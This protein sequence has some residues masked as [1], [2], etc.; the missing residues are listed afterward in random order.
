MDRPTI[1]E[2]GSHKT[3]GAPLT[4]HRST[5]PNSLYVFSFAPPIPPISQPKEFFDHPI[6]L[7]VIGTIAA[8]IAG[9]A[10]PAFDIITGVWTN[11]ITAAGAT[12]SQIIAGG[13]KAGWI[14]AVVGFVFFG[15]FGLFLYCCESP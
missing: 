7:Y 12:D 4:A 15:L 3:L 1:L 8:L 13:S 6:I 2:E 5:L 10:L 11:D 14:M 9:V